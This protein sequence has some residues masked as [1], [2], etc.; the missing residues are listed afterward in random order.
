MRISLDG[1]NYIPLRP[2][3]ITL[4]K[5]PCGRHYGYESGTFKL[6]KS[7]VGDNIVV[8]L[9]FEHEFGTTV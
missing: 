7:I 2:I 4:N 5:F 1:E 3:G 8:Q 6:P 9:E